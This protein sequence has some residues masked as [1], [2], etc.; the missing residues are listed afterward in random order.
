MPSHKH[1][2]DESIYNLIPRPQVVAPKAPRYESILS[3]FKRTSSIF[4]NK[5]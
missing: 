4:T 3:F 2:Q 5:D 1:I